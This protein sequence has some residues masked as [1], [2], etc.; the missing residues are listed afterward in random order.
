MRKTLL[1]VIL[2]LFIILASC[3]QN[4]DTK[5]QDEAQLIKERAALEKAAQEFLEENKATPLKPSPLPNQVEEDDVV[6]IEEDYPQIDDETEDSE[7]SS[8][9]YVAD[10]EEESVKPSTGSVDIKITDASFRIPTKFDFG[11]DEVEVSI[12]VEETGL[13]DGEFFIIEVVA[14]KSGTIEDSCQILFEV[15]SNEDTECSLDD[16]DKYGKYK[17]EVFA[18]IKDVYTDRDKDLDNNVYREEFEIENDN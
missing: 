15:G 18:D 9:N 3:A 11:E 4:T 1:S 8:D 13:N 14:R 5:A 12:D 7:S 17:V 10:E 2:V 16:I 6:I